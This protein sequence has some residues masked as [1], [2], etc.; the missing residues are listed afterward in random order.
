MDVRRRS[1]LFC[2]LGLALFLLI[3]QSN[4][5]P[6]L[7]GAH[8]ISETVVRP[9]AIP[10]PTPTDERGSS[11]SL[12]VAAVV[13]KTIS[14]IDQP[15]EKTNVSNK[16]EYSEAN[17]SEDQKS[18]SPI[19]QPTQKKIVSRIKFSSETAVEIPLP[20]N[21]STPTKTAHINQGSSKKNDFGQE[22]EPSSLSSSSSLSAQFQQ[23]L[24]LCEDVHETAPYLTDC[25][26]TN[27]KRGIPVL[28]IGN[29]RARSAYSWDILTSL[30]NAKYNNVSTN[31]GSTADHPQGFIEA[32]GAK[33][34]SEMRA[35][36]EHPTEPG[37][38]WI[39][40]VMCKLQHEN[41]DTKKKR[42]DTKPGEEPIRSAI[43]GTLWNPYLG[44]MKHK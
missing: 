34:I 39:A 4:V 38:C 37:H 9:A 29:S 23:D 27:P 1:I 10:S 17:D 33:S 24:A 8:G 14:P 32:F 5:N 21:Q 36:N 20:T 16:T 25:D 3:A 44:A 41:I 19:D 11:S 12:A 42:K 18:Q 30:A 43:F 2:I 28:W 13:E 15:P 31:A 35:L 22:K 6:S 26:L 7:P 40:R